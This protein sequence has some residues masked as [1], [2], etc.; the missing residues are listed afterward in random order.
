[1]TDSLNIIIEINPETEEIIIYNKEK[2]I[3]NL[4]LFE[5]VQVCQILNNIFVPSDF[6][7]CEVNSSTLN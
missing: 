7:S 2:V 4:S 5:A 3:C 1:M 6:T